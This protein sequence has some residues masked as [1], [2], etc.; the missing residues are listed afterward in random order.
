MRSGVKVVTVKTLRF[1][2]TTERPRAAV[3]WFRESGR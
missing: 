1:R 3:K 2:R